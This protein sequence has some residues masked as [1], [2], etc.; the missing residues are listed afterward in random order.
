MLL[1]APG[2]L[3][4]SHTSVK[5]KGRESTAVC[6]NVSVM[7]ILKEDNSSPHPGFFFCTRRHIGGQTWHMK[8]N[9]KNCL[10]AKLGFPRAHWHTKGTQRWNVETCNLSILR[11]A[12]PLP[13]PGYLHQTPGHHQQREQSCWPES[14]LQG[15]VDLIVLSPIS[16]LP[17]P[18]LSSHW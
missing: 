14:C 13:S 4:N 5:S 17:S 1:V 15:P 11:L 9:R 6:G 10:L 12:L 18:E 2:S 3:P 7:W 8:K 16:K